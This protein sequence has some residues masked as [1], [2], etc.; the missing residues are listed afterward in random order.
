MFMATP[1]ITAKRWKQLA[2]PLT[3]KRITKFSC[4]CVC[5]CVCVCTYRIL[6][7]KERKL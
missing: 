1:F 5:V 4:V 7:Y 6:P 2:C 3:D